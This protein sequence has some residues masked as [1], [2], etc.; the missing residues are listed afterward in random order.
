MS[1]HPTVW[2]DLMVSKKE[3]KNE[4]DGVDIDTIPAKRQYLKTLVT[5]SM[6]SMIYN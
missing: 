1:M 4:G 2:E 3:H 5:L 6:T